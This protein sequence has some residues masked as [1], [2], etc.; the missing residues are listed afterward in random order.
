MSNSDI[1]TKFAHNFFLQIAAE[2]GII[3]LFIILIVLFLLIKSI[4]KLYVQRKINLESW[5]YSTAI[6][7]FLAYS[8]IDISFYYPSIGI[9]GCLCL[10][11]YL[12]LFIEKREKREYYQHYFFPQNIILLIVL[13]GLIIYAGNLLFKE[14]LLENSLN[15]LKNNNFKKSIYYAKNYYKYFSYDLNSGL[16]LAEISRKQSSSEENINLQ[17]YIAEKYPYSARINY[18]LGVDNYQ[19][20]FLYNSFINFSISMS[21]YPINSVYRD[22][23]NKAL[24]F[25][26]N[27]NFNEKK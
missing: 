26:R 1:E 20:G 25:V 9:F 22:A 18:F 10:S 11:F 21:L 15:E 19:K 24:S 13:F 16:I 4:L 27:L 5:A 2:S 7:I 23:Y 17:N 8:C 3:G 6:L 12:S 14:K